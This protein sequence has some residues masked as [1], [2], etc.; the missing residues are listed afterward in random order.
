MKHG[1]AETLL[2]IGAL[3]MVIGGLLMVSNNYAS[4]DECPATSLQESCR[5]ETSLAQRPL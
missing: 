3:L 4:N 5:G 2:V 1:L